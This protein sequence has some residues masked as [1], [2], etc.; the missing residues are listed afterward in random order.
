MK[1][2]VIALCAVVLVS[3]AATSCKKQCTCHV[4]VA[5]VEVLSQDMGKMKKADCESSNSSVNVAGFTGAEVACN[6]E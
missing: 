2:T 4:K 5:G 1:K 3:L 6:L